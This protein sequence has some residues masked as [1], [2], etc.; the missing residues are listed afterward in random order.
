MEWIGIIA[1]FIVLA[2]VYRKELKKKDKLIEL[3]TRALE[4][5][6][7]K[8][9]NLSRDISNLM[10]WNGHSSFLKARLKYKSLKQVDEATWYGDRDAKSN[11]M[12]GIYPLMKKAVEED[13]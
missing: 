7:S 3:Y 9:K 2:L 6:K 8:N 4:I 11:E 5:E 12:Q 13:E 1:F 10:G